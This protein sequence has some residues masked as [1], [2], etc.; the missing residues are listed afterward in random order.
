M[1]RVIV[2]NLPKNITEGRLREVFSAVGEVTDVRLLKTA[3]GQFR[4]FAFVG[5][6]TE[7]Q[8]GAAVSFF[9]QS[10]IDT[11][12]LEVEIAKTFGDPSLPRPWS[13]YSKGS[14]AFEKRE[15]QQKARQA[16]VETKKNE[17]P[18]HHPR[19]N[20]L[21]EQSKT[22]Q[23]LKKLYEVEEDPQ[24]Q[25][26]LQTV[27]PK[28]HV[29]K[30]ADDTVMSSTDKTLSTTTDDR[31]Q[32]MK[33]KPS[34]A[35]VP[36]KKPGGEAVVYTRSHLKFDDDDSEEV[37][38]TEDGDS[39]KQD[40]KQDTAVSDLEYLKS[41]VVSMM[42]NTASKGNEMKEN[43]V[44]S[45]HGSDNE[46]TDSKEAA[47]NT[48]D[49]SSLHTLKMLGLPFKATEHD[50]Q[51]FFA[52]ISI[53]E[54]RLITNKEER[55][56]GRAFVDFSSNEDL[57][58]A[59]KRDKDYMDGRYIELFIDDGSTLNHSEKEME[60]DDKPDPPWIAKAANLPGE[61]ESIADSGRL[62]VR[63][64]SYSC[65]DEDL[66][67]LF[68]KYGPLSEVLVPIDRATKKCKGIAFITFLMPEHGVL[69]FNELDKQIFQG[70][71]L[72]ILPARTPFTKNV[73]HNMDA[74]NKSFKGKRE[75]QAKK[76]SQSSYNWNT[77]FL[78]SNA[79]ADAMAS[80][81]GTQKST[82]LSSEASQS[83]AVRMALGE[84]HIVQETKQ[85]LEE[86]GVQLS[87]FDEVVKERSK[88]VILVK[89]LSFG[90]SESELRGV[91][92]KCGDIGRIVLPPAGITALVEFLEASDAKKAFT[93]LAY[94]KFKDVPLY[95]EW[96]PLQSFLNPFQATKEDPYEQASSD[97]DHEDTALEG[98][99]QCTLFIKNLN[100]K[101]TDNRLEE[102]FSKSG[103]LRSAVIAKKQDAKKP[104]S[105]KAVVY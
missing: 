25:E 43:R 73:G 91:F 38:C 40:L 45:K 11:S 78:G 21:K 75:D 60:M 71:L 79:V 47:K 28:S 86:H 7:K 100:F 34:F 22:Y 67:R 30:W 48:V 32:R 69:A 50:I 36:S 56:S 9:N 44:R 95:L 94:T 87:V 52:P 55:P 27:K 33:V 4:R 51:E 5:Y 15:E 77:L 89:N 49:V 98:G 99:H 93:K 59:L 14:S 88:S 70:R 80:K 58:E 63:N 105:H 57:Q 46:K 62:F 6:K 54:I 74:D 104:G 64:L 37:L 16:A 81:F 85:F 84:S 72:H 101:T 68:S 83:L 41:K 90:T 23:L 1:S 8:A 19:A 39:K 53:G 42:D 97:S 92:S 29:S 96:A 17:E 66:E 82:I 103:P 31:D 26:F 65:T 24:F 102:V 10:F 61:E 35:T 12:K 76:T 2:K 3:R 20:L 13:K 18:L